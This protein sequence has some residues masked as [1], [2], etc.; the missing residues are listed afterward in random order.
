MAYRRTLSIR[1]TLLAR[2]F[3]PSFSYL[4]HDNDRSKQE[5]LQPSGSTLKN[6]L[7]QRRSFGSFVNTHSGQFSG[8]FQRTGSMFMG[9]G[10]CLN[11]YMST[12]TEQNDRMNYTSDV[13]DAITEVPME[14]GGVF[15]DAPIEVIASQA[16][17]VS[18]VALAAA[19]SA[20]PVAALQY[21]IEG[22]QTFTGFNWWACIALTTLLI[23]LATVPFLINQ[24][25]ATSKLTLLR[26][27]LEEI[28]AEMEETGMEPQ[29]VAEGQ[30][31]MKALFNEYGVTPFTPMKGLFIQ[32]PVFISFF[33]GITN[34]AEKV[35]SFKNGGAFWFTDLTVPD[36]MYI[37]PVLTA[38]SFLA[39]VEFNMQEGL[40]GNPVAGTMK[41]FSRGL[42]VVTVPFTMNFP[43]AIFCYWIT[44]NLFSFC[45]GSVLRIPG[46]KKALGVPEIPV[47]PPSETKNKPSSGF[48]FLEALKQASSGNKSTPAISAPVQKSSSVDK[49]T[50]STAALSQRL[51]NLEKQVKQKKRL[52]KR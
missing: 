18:E 14:A 32:G 39:T 51:R 49:K 22:V 52:K 27:R 33:L 46:V 8:S 7:D 44:S 11:R 10:L 20:Y 3:N 40:E 42:A 4:S 36:A 28:K 5:E 34:M 25:K 30:K 48:S 17:A 6:Y 41:K 15:T 16:P 45:Y 12:S 47:A 50:S 37:F 2:K 23:R 31:K 24:L 35:P 1:S 9:S 29:A 19:D 43:Q 21:L 38:L 26:P 13:M